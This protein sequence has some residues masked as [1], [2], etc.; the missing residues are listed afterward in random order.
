MNTTSATTQLGTIS[1][2]ARIDGSGEEH[3]PGPL[4]TPRLDRPPAAGDSITLPGGGAVVHNRMAGTVEVRIVGEVDLF[5]RSVFNEVFA[6]LE[7]ETAPFLYVLADDATFIESACLD[8]IA[9][10]AVVRERAGGRTVV[11]GLREPFATAWSEASRRWMDRGT[12][13]LDTT[14]EAA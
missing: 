10:T 1:T 13:N 14:P 9:R 2:V 4:P 12:A 7:S 6:V 5:D 3:T 11:C 8:V